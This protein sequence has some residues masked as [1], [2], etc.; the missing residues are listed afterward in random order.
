[1]RHADRPGA[2]L[3]FPGGNESRQPCLGLLPVSA[4]E[5]EEQDAQPEGQPP[6]L[7]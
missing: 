2:H 4:K 1:M 5:A 7:K 6:A 3:V